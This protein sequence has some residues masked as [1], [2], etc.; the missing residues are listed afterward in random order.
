[1]NIMDFE[2]S[3]VWEQG[4]QSDIDHAIQQMPRPSTRDE[5]E[6]V[7]SYIRAEAR[8]VARAFHSHLLSRLESARTALKHAEWR[9]EQALEDLNRVSQ[10]LKDLPPANRMQAYFYLVCSVAALS[11]EFWLN[12]VTLS[13]MLSIAAGSFEGIAIAAA[14]TT[15]VAGMKL[16]FSR[17]LEEPWQRVGQVNRPVWISALMAVFLVILGGLNLATLTLLGLAREDAMAIMASLLGS[18]A[19][20]LAGVTFAHL[21]LALVFVTVSVGVSGSWFL[22]LTI[23]EFRFL[24]LQ[25]TLIRDQNAA[26]DELESHQEERN[27]AAA[28]LGVCVDRWENR[29]EHCRAQEDHYIAHKLFKLDQQQGSPQYIYPKTRNEKDRV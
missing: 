21:N 8:L 6:S 19:S 9:G 2:I 14:A 4:D 27:R 23:Q 18:D 1:M 11:G 25:R 15:S 3:N 28:E 24:G 22:L 17:T 20:L 29:E 13:F 26:E 16:V 12:L 5:L 7:K 10:R